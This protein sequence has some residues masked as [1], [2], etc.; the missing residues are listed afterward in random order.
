MKFTF[1]TL[2]V[3]TTSRYAGNP[4]AV[5]QVPASAK[6]SISQQQKQAI[7]NEFNLSEIIFLHLPLPGS[8]FSEVAIDIFTSFAEIPFAGHPTLG[9]SHFLL[10]VLGKKTQAVITK[11]G[12]IPIVADV[13]NG[14]VKASIPHDVHIHK[15]TFPS[16]LNSLM[17]VMVSI[18]KGMSFIFV[19]LPDLSTL[20]RASRILANSTY[21]V[22]LLDEGWQS[23]LIGTMYLVS[24]GVDE[25]GRHKYRTRMF[26]D[27]MEDPGTGS[28]SCALACWLALKKPKDSGVGPFK[29]AFTQGIEMGR[30]NDIAVEV[31]RDDSGEGIKEVILSGAAVKV[32]EGTLEI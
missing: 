5:V 15:V 8:S 6:S 19:E 17:N 20:G 25:S 26:A 30:Q 29:F 23:G 11:A 16:E 9:A 22:L 24:L 21:D 28:A 4:L 3:F 10:N 7:A 1:T 12:R 2:D 13:E 31:T 14:L 18:V 27:G 32:M